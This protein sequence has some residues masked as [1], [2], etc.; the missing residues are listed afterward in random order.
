[1]KRASDFRAIAREALREKWLMAALAGF[2]ASLL[3]GTIATGGNLSGSSSFPEDSESLEEFFYSDFWYEYSGIIITVFILIL[4]FAVIWSL[5]LMVVGGAA[6]LGYARYNL[7]LIDGKKASL[8][9][10][11]SQFHRLLDGFLMQLLQ[12]LYLFLWSLLFIIPGIIKAY[13]YAMTP[14][15]MSEKPHLSVNEAITESRRIMDGNKWRLF[16]LEWSF[17]GWWLLCALP[18]VIGVA[19]S[20]GLGILTENPF[21]VLAF[22]PSLL[23]VWAAFCFLRPYNEAAWAAFYRD[24]SAESASSVEDTME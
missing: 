12:G 21:W 11:I 10:L 5:A 14:Y 6:K 9:D 7:H 15:I 20:V 23:P 13:S 17:I 16:C 2:I 8:A 22:L 18:L 3:G 4:L 19:G 24:V 1:M